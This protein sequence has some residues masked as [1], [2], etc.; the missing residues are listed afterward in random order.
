MNRQRI[1]IRE[2]VKNLSLGALASAAGCYLPPP[3]QGGYQQPYQQQH[4]QGAASSCA[5]PAPATSPAAAPA[6]ATRQLHVQSRPGGMAVSAPYANAYLGTTPCAFPWADSN[7]SGPRTED[8]LQFTL[9]GRTVLVLVDL[10]SSS[11]MIDA[12]RSPA[13]VLGGVLISDSGSGYAAQPAPTAA[14]QQ[15]T[16]CMWCKNYFPN[17]FEH[18]NQTGCSMGRPGGSAPAQP[19]QPQPGMSAERWA[20]AAVSRLQQNMQ[21]PNFA[22]MM[23]NQIQAHTHPSG[24]S[25]SMAQFLPGRAMGGNTRVVVTF[26]VNWRGGLVGSAYTTQVQWVFSQAGQESV[27]VTGD[28]APTSVAESNK[29]QLANYFRQLYDELKLQIR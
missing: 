3:Q 8:Q 28:N 17:V 9:D 26:T 7:P 23:A 29:Q 14:T 16:Q 6:S 10:G 24:N 20:Q 25:A 13:T 19:A 2:F 5:A 4:Y 22:Q 12:T 21:N 18:Q 11:L 1:D 15:R 27:T